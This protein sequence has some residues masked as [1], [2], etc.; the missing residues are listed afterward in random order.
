MGLPAANCC[1]STRGG[2][3]QDWFVDGQLLEQARSN[4]NTAK[5]CI[6]E[7]EGGWTF[8]TVAGLGMK[9]ESRRSTPLSATSCAPRAPVA[10]HASCT[11]CSSR[12]YVLSSSYIASAGAGNIA[13]VV[14][15]G[16][17]LAT[18]S[19]LRA[20][21]LI[22]HLTPSPETPHRGIGHQATHDD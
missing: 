18:V 19:Y 20:E 3:A 16:C 12:P 11:T 5:I 10:S 17:G 14:R 22:N 21:D 4:L 2:G 7:G 6:K 15:H 13:R 9:I 8:S 1:W